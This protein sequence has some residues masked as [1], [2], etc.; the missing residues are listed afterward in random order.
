MSPVII[1]IDFQRWLEEGEVW[2]TREEKCTYYSTLRVPLLTHFHCRHIGW[3]NGVREC[4]RD[5][6]PNAW[7]SI[8]LHWCTDCELEPAVVFIC[9]IVQRAFFEPIKLTDK[10]LFISRTDGRPTGDAF[11]QFDTEEE[12]QQALQKHRHVIGQRYIELF[13]STAAEVQQVVKRCNM[14]NSSPAVAPAS[15]APEEKK[16]DCVRLRGLPY[17]ATVSCGSGAGRCGVVLFYHLGG[18]LP[19]FVAVLSREIG[20]VPR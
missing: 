16:K 7:S 5:H 17:E 2:R 20:S 3:S 11:V 10:I 6:R 9:L 13:K 15:E 1:L 8:R 4:Q 18:F 14:I 19:S 12:A